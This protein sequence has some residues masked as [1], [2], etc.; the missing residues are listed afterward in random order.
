MVEGITNDKM[1]FQLSH[2]ENVTPSLVWTSGS[3]LHR[4]DVA[5]F[6]QVPLAR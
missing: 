3:V 4:P 1:S 5:G 2:A 6:A